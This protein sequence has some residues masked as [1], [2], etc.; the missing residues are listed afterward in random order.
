MIGVVIKIVLGIFI[1]CLELSD[2]F[3]GIVIRTDK[4]IVNNI[5]NNTSN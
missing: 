2:N 4:Y 3:I 5:I 1:S